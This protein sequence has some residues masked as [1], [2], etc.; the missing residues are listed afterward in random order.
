MRVQTHLIALCCD[1]CVLLL[2]R[3]EVGLLVTVCLQP[4]KQPW[5]SSCWSQSDVCKT[6]FKTSAS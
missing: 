1:C 6:S 3:R 2:T 5:L 4:H